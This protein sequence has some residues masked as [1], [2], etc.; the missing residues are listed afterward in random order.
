MATSPLRASAPLRDKS[1]W[2]VKKLGEVCD[3]E[4]GS[5]PPKSQFIYEPKD[6]YVRFLQIRDFGSDKNITYIP[7]SPKNRLCIE[8]DILIGRYGASVG[9][10]LNGKAGAYNV[11]LMKTDPD[12]SVLNREWF[13]SYLL[14]SEFQ[15]RLLNVAERSA[16][17]GFSKD[18]IFN[19]PVPV[20][21]LP[22]QERIVGILDEAFDGIAKA[23][24]TAEANLQNARALFQSH[25]QTVFSQKGEGWVETTIGAATKGV[26][27]G[28]FGSLLHKSDYVEN[29]IPLVNPAHISEMGIEPDYKKSVSE[30]T[31]K[32]LQSYIM[33][34]GDVVIGRRGEMGR[35]AVITNAEDGWLCGTGSFFLKPSNVC[36][37][38]FLVRFLRSEGCKKQLE[39][40]AGGALMPNL[41]NTALSEFPIVLP[42]MTVQQ[43]INEKIENIAEETQRLESLYQNKLNALDELK[44]SLLHQAFTGNL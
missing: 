3:F 14:S 20:P 15:D 9:K 7:H 25:L 6:G 43:S 2:S 27:T 8:N 1:D 22:E 32:R 28:P 13:H 23:K 18:D 39:K 36:D 34:E 35:C 38:W 11:A 26:F 29:G 12:L 10:I 5:Q 16:Q 24:A 44:K 37:P 4:G 40:I 31:A 30:E 42:P 21:P 41:S 33:H 19:F 17:A